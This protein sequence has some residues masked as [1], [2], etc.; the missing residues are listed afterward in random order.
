MSV[1][2]A[3]AVSV[4]TNLHSHVGLTS[5]SKTGN[6]GLCSCPHLQHRLNPDSQLM[7]ASPRGRESLAASG[8]L[9][10][11]VR[12]HRCVNTFISL[13]LPT[14]PEPLSTQGA[15]PHTLTPKHL[16]PVPSLQFKGKMFYHFKCFSRK[17]KFF[18]ECA[19]K[20]VFILK[21]FR[22]ANPTK[23]QGTPQSHSDTAV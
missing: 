2:L 1:P 13:C 20:S 10:P 23:K 5:P 7:G 8:G 9:K 12:P 16:L 17:I 22:N 6:T 14:C 21:Y 4:N 18:P 11:E 19:R 3:K 15:S